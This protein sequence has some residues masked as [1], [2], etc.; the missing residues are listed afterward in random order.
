M[1]REGL[2]SRKSMMGVV[3]LREGMSGRCGCVDGH[4]ILRKEG[5]WKLVADCFS[6][7]ALCGMKRKWRVT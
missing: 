6:S 4:G 1:G 5:R 3:S 2:P 7:G